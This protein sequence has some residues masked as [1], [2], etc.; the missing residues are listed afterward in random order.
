MAPVDTVIDWYDDL[1]AA[2]ANV[3]ADEAIAAT[4]RQTATAF[5]EA[6]ARTGH[7]E[8]LEEG[9]P[10][11]ALVILFGGIET[12]QSALLN[13]LWALALDQDAQLAVRHDR[14]RLAGAIEES[15]RWEPAVM[16]LTRFTTADTALGGQLIPADSGIECLIAG[17]NRDPAAFDDPDRFDI[18]R[19]NSADHFTFGYGRHHCLGAHL[20]RMEM[21][22]FI[23]ALLD[24]SPGGFGF[25]DEQQPKPRGHEFR[26]PPRLALAW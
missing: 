19:S 8:L 6:L 13:A 11:N 5:R 9:R 20:A 10:N 21:T 17:A 1:A 18:G 14:S 12:T 15:L 2:L 26:R 23:A 24:R 22:E 3:M 25:A 7:G 4:G 16:T